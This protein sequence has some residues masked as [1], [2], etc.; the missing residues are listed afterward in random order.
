LEDDVSIL[1]IVGT[2]VHRACYERE[3]GQTATWSQPLI[4]YLENR[5]A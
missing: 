3:T 4:C 1:P 2:L 5:A